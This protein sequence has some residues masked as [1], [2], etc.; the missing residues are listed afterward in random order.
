[1]NVVVT[2]GAHEQS[3][4]FAELAALTCW[5]LFAA[6][7]TRALR[8]TCNTTARVQLEVTLFALHNVAP[9][10]VAP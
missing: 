1:M 6:L 2:P 3:A 7:L 10:N 5:K 4:P 8:F 9:R